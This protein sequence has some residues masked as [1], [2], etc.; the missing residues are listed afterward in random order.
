MKVMLLAA[1]RGTRMRPLTDHTPKPLL[2]VAGQPLIVWHLQRLAAAGL[3]QVVI[4]L[5]HLG[6]QIADCLGDG[7][8]WGLQIHY[9][10]EAELLETA[11]G[12]IQALP[13]LGAQPF[14]L[15]NADVWT[16]LDFAQL[17][18][19]LPDEAD[20]HLVLVPNAAHHPQ[21]D[22]ALAPDRRLLPANAGFPVY[23]YSGVA[24]MRPQLFADWPPGVLPLR[25]VLERALAAGRVQGELYRG[26]W[27][28]IGTPQ[29]LQALSD[30][31]RAQSASKAG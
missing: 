9:S 23:T 29:R 10:R 7:S 27:H 6:E 3:Q 15:V 14:L 8:A 31:L 1:G 20:A 25:P 5:H 11:G 26:E 12:I 18:S 4:N 24:V 2:P 19:R 30:R 17:C 22:F 21:G 16:D 28:D 13:L